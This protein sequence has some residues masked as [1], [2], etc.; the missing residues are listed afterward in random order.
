MRWA[1]NTLDTAPRIRYNTVAH[2]KK[3][4]SSFRGRAVAVGVIILQVGKAVLMGKAICCCGWVLVVTGLLLPVAS[5]S[6]ESCSLEIKK[7]DPSSTS[8]DTYLFRAT[9]S[10]SFFLPVGEG[11]RFRDN[12]AQEFAGVIKKEPESYRAVHPVRGV[13]RLGTQKFAYVLDTSVEPEKEKKDAEESEGKE[14][15]SEKSEGVLS[16]LAKVLT[17]GEKKPDKDKPDKNRPFKPVPYDRLYFDRDGD[18][19]LTDEEVIE[20]SSTRDLNNNRYFACTFPRIDLTIEVESE[21]V[22]YAMV[23][24]TTAYDGGNY[25]YV[26]GSFSAGA[27]REGELTVDGKKRRLVL[28][29]FNANGRFD[30]A[31][32]FESSVR[33]SD[34]QV[35]PILGDRLYVDP[36]M[37][38]T[39]RSPYDV[40]SGD[41]LFDVGSLLCLEG[42]FYKMTVSPSGDK[43]TLEPADVEL[44]YVTNA[45]GEYRAVVYGDAGLLKLR[46]DESG[47]APVPVGSWKLMNYTLDRTGFEPEKKPEENAEPSILGV[48]TDALEAA[49]PV[50]PPRQTFVAANATTAYEAVEVKKGETVK[51]PF[52][53]PYR[54]QVDVQYRSGADEVSLGMS[55]VGSAGEICSNMYV[56]GNRP[57]KPAFTITGPDGEKVAEGAFEY[58]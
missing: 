20:A 13:V 10:Q 19:D 26:N 4:V 32:R 15:K 50:G 5:A 9:S 27:Y 11:V 31:S 7:V 29:D 57:E 53:P 23:L 35:R 55:L 42:K 6:G 37:K 49:A 17:G 51:L 33:Y 12:Q 45:V 47:K 46:S 41:D 1:D 2:R 28:I 40:T 30:D 3:G 43:L 34:G 21:S 58:G 54:P 39:Y 14:E 36:D 16:A 44:G 22:D 38:A 48:L 18:G 8:N 56:N 25:G 52:G 24:N